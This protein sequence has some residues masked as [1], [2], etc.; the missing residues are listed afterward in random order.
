MWTFRRLGKISWKEKKTNQEVCDILDIRPTLLKVIKTRKLRY[1]GHLRR[2]QTITKDILEGSVEGKRGRGRP[3][4]TWIDNVK[5][6]TGLSAAECSQ[7]AVNRE[8]WRVISSRPQ[9][10][11]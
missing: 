5:T 6:W 1:F 7:Q 10:K 8:E 11:R 9:P 3:T 2:H 4:R